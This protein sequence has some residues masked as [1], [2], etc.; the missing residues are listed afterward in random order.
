MPYCLRVFVNRCNEDGCFEIPT[1][2]VFDTR[3]NSIG[4][5]CMKHGEKIMCERN[6]ELK[7]GMRTW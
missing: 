6:D 4:K 5:Y 3:Y 1:V 2:E 7:R